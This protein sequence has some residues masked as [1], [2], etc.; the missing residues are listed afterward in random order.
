MSKLTIHALMG[1][2]A[3]VAIAG[4]AQAGTMNGGGASLPG[5][6][7]RLAADCYGST[8]PLYNAGAAP[9]NPTPFVYTDPNTMVTT[10]CAV[11]KVAP[12]DTVN[13]VSNGSGAGRQGFVTHDPAKFGDIDPITAGIQALSS[14]QFAMSDAGVSQADFNVYNNGGTNSDGVQVAAPFTAPVGA[15]VTN[16]E[17][18]YGAAIQIPALIAPV[19]IAFDPVYKKTLSADGSTVTEYKFRLKKPVKATIGGVATTVGGLQLDADTYCKIF[20]GTITNFNDPAITALNGGQS[21]KDVADPT[22][23]FSV[24]IVMVGRSDSSGTTSI[25]TRH[26]GAVCAAVAGNQYNT[27]A[28]TTTLPVALRGPTYD[29]T[30]ANTDPTALSAALAASKYVI[31]AGNDGVAKYIDFTAAPTTPGSSLTWGRIGYAGSDFALPASRTTLLGTPLATA[32][33]YYATL[34]N[35]AAKFVGPTAT[36]AQ[37]AF[38]TLL[39]PQTDPVTKKYSASYTANGLR[40]NPADW[41]QGLSTSSPLADPTDPSAYN[42]VG[43]S[44][45]LLYTCYAGTTTAPAVNGFLNFYYKAKIVTDK[46]T[47]ILGLSGF[48]AVPSTFITAIQETFTKPSKTSMA[49]NLYIANANAGTTGPC[50]AQTGLVGG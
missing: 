35:H 8:Q 1:A 39:P 23:V 5:P 2:T 18:A 19:A 25:W 40:S 15:Q 36:G 14:V 3:L 11:T 50:V 44:N 34:K 49:W 9:T 24:P 33:L 47:G 42:I 6:Y 10:D 28:G 43:T 38:G 17:V 46:K 26:L 27:T 12:G 31:A 16:P 7:I 41:V 37:K 32:D 20:N 48:S 21:L 45:F 29:K 22:P 13:Y 4:S 30:K